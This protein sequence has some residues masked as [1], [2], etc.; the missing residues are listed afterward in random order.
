VTVRGRA[1][2][3]DL[4][5]AAPA[6]PRL[7]W[8]REVVLI[9]AFYL[10]YSLIRNHFG[11]AAVSPTEAYSNTQ[12]IIDLETRLGVFHE[13]TV[14]G[15]F[16]GWHA[17]IV[18]WDTFYGLL[19]FVVP[20]ATL[21]FLFFRWPADH[22]GLRNAL[23]FTTGLALVGFSLFPVMP[24]RLL[25]AC[26]YGAGP[27]ATHYGFVDTMVSDGGLWSFGSSGVAAVSNQYAAMPSLHMAWA[28]W[29]ALALVPR[30]RRP[31]QQVLAAAYPAMTAFAVIVTANH[32]FLD[33]VG[34]AVVLG[35]GWTLSR[36]C[37]GWTE[38]R[39]RTSSREDLSGVL[40]GEPATGVPL[41]LT[42]VDRGWTA[43]AGRSATP[44]EREM[45]LP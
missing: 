18:F 3:A 11:S 6:A 5:G 40:V 37:T 43:R 30:L 38:S 28:L 36:W 9:G 41:D 1:G 29:C 35:I 45:P 42:S 21:V 12:H 23:A 22:R 20:M 10:G 32:F 13:A 44:A 34:G 19:H 8:W 15:W 17:F 16:L 7:R 27:G 25:C 14:Q 4:P 33:V 39:R 31:W 26:T 24:P 2:S